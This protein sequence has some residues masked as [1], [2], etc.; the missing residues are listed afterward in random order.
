MIRNLYSSIGSPLIFLVI[1][2][3]LTIWLDYV[4]RPP[5]YIKDAGLYRNPDHIVENLIGVRVD[6]EHGI[7]RQFTAKRLFHYLDDEVT[8]LEQVSFTNLDSEKPPMRLSADLAVVRNKG[9]D[10]D[11]MENIVAVRGTDEDKAKITLTTDFLHLD[12]DENLVTTDRTV[13]ISRLDTTIQALGL[14]FNNRIGEI[15]LLSNVKA[16]NKK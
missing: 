1:L 12:P 8:Q 13:T 3:P 14:E 15:R 11:L 2:A 6:H 4:T 16:I 5:A 9:K 10:I 7:Q